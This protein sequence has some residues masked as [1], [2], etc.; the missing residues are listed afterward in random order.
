M[1]EERNKHPGWAVRTK[2]G[3]WLSYAHGFHLSEDAFYARV[4]DSEEDAKH[5]IKQACEDFGNSVLFSV[6]LAWE[7][8]C[9]Q[10]RFQVSSLKKANTLSPNKI[11][12]VILSLEDAISTLQG[13]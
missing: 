2:T 5:L 7:P 13:K 12:D 6:V 3:H 9:E 1:R 10:L 8:L 4:V 11:D